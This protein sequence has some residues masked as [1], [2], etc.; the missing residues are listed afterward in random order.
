[1]TL[2]QL[3]K[4]VIAHGFKAQMS[5]RGF[6]ESNKSKLLFFRKNNDNI[7]QIINFEILSGGENL[8]ILVFNWVPELVEGYDIAN[9]PKSLTITNG[10]YITKKGRIG[11]GAKFW[12]LRD[13]S[14][15]N[16]HLDDILGDIDKFAIPWFEEIKTRSDL[17]SIIFPDTKEKPTFASVKERVLNASV[18]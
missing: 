3:R 4:M 16:T 8:R 9:F 2:A 7:Y 1:M 10:D 5:E 6:E 12:D 14:Q 17:I 18:M 11:L 15:I 13:H